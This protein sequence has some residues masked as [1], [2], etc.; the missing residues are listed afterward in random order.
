M[1]SFIKSC[2]MLLVL[3]SATTPAFAQ[4]RTGNTTI[5]YRL[6]R[7]KTI[8]FDDQQTA[9]KHLE[10]VK[11]LGCEASSEMHEGHP[12]VTYRCPE[13]KSLTVESDKLAHQ[14]QSWLIASG[15]QT[16]HG[17]PANDAHGHSHAGGADH[18]HDHG[19]AAR[20]EAISYRL[21]DWKTQQHETKVSANSFVAVTKGLGCEVK[22]TEESGVFMVSYR[23]RTEMI[24]DLPSHDA[25][26][27]WEQWLNKTGFQTSHQH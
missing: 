8:H 5:A 17:H 1:K 3:A 27:A 21:R 10:V 6:T 24:L 15:F 20:G 19:H 18:D 9:D 25:A 4:E 23:C 2:L 13:W 7:A 16:L 26:H 12:D 14:W 22:S 11:R